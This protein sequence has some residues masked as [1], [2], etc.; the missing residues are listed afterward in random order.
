MLTRR[1]LEV[2]LNDLMQEF[3]LLGLDPKKVILFGSYA[4][5]GVHMHSDIDIA[6][7]SHKF[8]GEG[9]IDFEIIRPIIR[10]F[11]NL[12]IKMYPIGATADNFDPFIKVI[13]S[14]GRKIDINSSSLIL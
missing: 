3:F 10:K 13:E 4:N 8:I 7:W 2:L 14:T 9:M 6:I 12:D 5:G 11:K 1:S